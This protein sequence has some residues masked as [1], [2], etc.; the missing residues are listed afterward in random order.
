MGGTP[1]TF[2]ARTFYTYSHDDAI[3]AVANHVADGAAVDSLVYEFALARE[4]ELANKVRVIHQS[5]AFGIP[6]VVISPEMRPQLAAELQSI[7][8]NMADD[9][10]GQTALSVAGIERFVLIDDTAY[11]SVRTL[12]ET[13]N[14]EQ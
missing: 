4:P 14:S 10:A 9:P 6:P 11:D 13:V 7:L 8:I 12:E 2:F 3:H 1:A 5:P